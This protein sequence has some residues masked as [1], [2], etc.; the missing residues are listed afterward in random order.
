MGVPSAALKCSIAAMLLSL[1][2]CGRGG[3]TAQSTSELQSVRADGSS[4]V[5]PISEAVAEEFRR[6][7]PDI[8]VT[9]GVWPRRSSS[10]CRRATSDIMPLSRRA[11]LD[12]PRYVRRASRRRRTRRD[13]DSGR[14]TLSLVAI[15]ARSPGRQ[16]CRSTIDTAMA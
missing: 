8:R 7:H 15:R 16:L 3:D 14:Q 12:W 10:S 11:E 6:D 2:A 9:V 4:T 5:F 13:L 1:A